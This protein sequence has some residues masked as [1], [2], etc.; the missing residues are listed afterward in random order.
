MPAAS[1]SFDARVEQLLEG[2]EEQVLHRDPERQDAVQELR[3][4]RQFLAQRAVLVD[5]IEPG[6]VLEI[7]E[8]AALDLPGVKQLV[9]LAQC[10]LGVG[11]FEIV[12]GAEQALAAGLALAA[13]DG[14][15]VSRR[16]AIVDRKRFSPLTSV[17]TGRNTGGCFWLVRLERP[18]PWIAASAFQPGSS[19]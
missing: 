9:E 5:E 11:A 19:R 15:K 10:R 6:R 18:R 2:D 16:R 12:V 13:G 7:A 3:D 8:R 14:A 17:A 4:R 1:R